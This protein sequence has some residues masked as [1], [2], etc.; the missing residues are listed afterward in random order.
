MSTSITNPLAKHFRQP[1]IYLR[2]P[3]GGK[4]YPA[5]SLE[6]S[7]TGDFPVY[8]MTIKDEISFKTPDALMN[9]QG[10]ADVIVSC[11][12]N[13]K[14][15]WAIPV[16]DLDPILIAIR[17]ASYGPGMDIIS[18]CPK[19]KEVNENT[20]DLRVVL[21]SAVAFNEDKQTTKINNLTFSFKPQTY[22]DLNNSQQLMFE[23]QK[24]ISLISD[25]TLPD[26]EKQIRFNDSFNKLT[27]MNIDTLVVCINSIITDEEIKV[28][29]PIL[30]KD[31]LSNTDRKTYE[32]IK[33]H[34]EEF[35][36]SNAMEPVDI[37]CSECDYVY[38]TK[39]EFNQ[40]NFFD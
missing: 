39:L 25:S 28:V 6:L 21:D 32:T 8:P 14:N 24:I 16:I 19:C 20:I 34:I 31:F 7:A 13:I 37:T 36:T 30:I 10:M 38:K 3:S 9:G 4:F 33:N 5:G 23:Q 22:K 18:D 29:D 35:V 26:E 17:I 11:C 12:P 27:G 40:S 1:S 15:P 2:L